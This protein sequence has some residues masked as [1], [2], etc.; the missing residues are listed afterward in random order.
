ME[1]HPDQELRAQAGLTPAAKRSADAPKKV[2]RGTRYDFEGQSMTAAEVRAQFVPH[3]SEEWVRSALKA[4]CN[5]KAAMIARRQEL[6]AKA[7][8][9]TKKSSARSMWRDKPAAAFRRKSDAWG[10]K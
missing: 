2:A 9:S 1:K 8:A 6:E 3:F 4:G 10:K 7:V 5:S